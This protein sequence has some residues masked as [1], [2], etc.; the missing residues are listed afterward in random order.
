MSLPQFIPD[1]M[2]KAKIL[3]ALIEP[4]I[5]HLPY[6]SKRNILLYVKISIFVLYEDTTAV[7]YKFG[8][9]KRMSV[10]IKFK[11]RQLKHMRTLDGPDLWASVV[12]MYLAGVGLNKL[13]NFG[14]A[15]V[16]GSS[17]MTKRKRG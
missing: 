7:L 13:P 10:P 8:C 5:P 12:D 2:S 17:H 14:E 16:Q 15:S 3:S 11:K 6:M 9:M 4:I 1:E